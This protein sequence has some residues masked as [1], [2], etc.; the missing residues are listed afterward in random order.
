MAYQ[1]DLTH[2]RYG[3]EAYAPCVVVHDARMMACV[4]D[5]GNE[6]YRPIS[7]ISF[8]T[9]R[10]GGNYAESYAKVVRARL[11]DYASQRDVWISH[12]TSSDMLE[13]YGGSLLSPTEVAECILQVFHYGEV[14]LPPN[15]QD[16]EDARALIR[17]HKLVAKLLAHEL[18]AVESLVPPCQLS[19]A[20]LHK[21]LEEIHAR[22]ESLTLEGIRY[23]V[24]SYQMRLTK[25]T[26]RSCA[27]WWIE[28]LSR[29][30]TQP[31]V[32]WW[33]TA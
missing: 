31:V 8:N 22:L 4:D 15:P 30:G 17:A 32:G 7:K 23:Q 1:I 25:I 3:N 10:W 6:V 24:G 20:A 27:R 5:G 33:G 18:M 13:V 16:A 21:I 26:S 14:H 19:N 2:L 11:G 29:R 12:N 28:R 9:S